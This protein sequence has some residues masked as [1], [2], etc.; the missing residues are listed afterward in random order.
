MEILTIDNRQVI[1]C[2]HCNGDGICK[3]AVLRSGIDV[4][5]NDVTQWRECLKCGTGLVV[6][7]VGHEAPYPICAICGG[8]GYTVV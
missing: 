2:V 6:S 8:K 4:K 7:L 1:K 3:H 5:A